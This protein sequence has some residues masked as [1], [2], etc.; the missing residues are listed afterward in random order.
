MPLARWLS[1]TSALA[2]GKG[3]GVRGHRQILNLRTDQCHFALH[4]SALLPAP[5]P[6]AIQPHQHGLLCLRCCWSLLRRRGAGPLG[7]LL[8]LH[9]SLLA[10]PVGEQ[11]NFFGTDLGSTDPLEQVGCYAIR[12]RTGREHGCF[13]QGP[14][15]R[16]SLELGEQASGR[17]PAPPTPYR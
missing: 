14:T 2:P 1:G 17:T 12:P 15:D 5:H 11:P 8:L 7:L 13:L 6:A 3:R 10:A 9:R 16:A 4:P